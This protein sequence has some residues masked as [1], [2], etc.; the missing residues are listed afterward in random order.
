MLQPFRCGRENLNAL[1][2][3]TEQAVQH[4]AYVWIIVNDKY[5]LIIRG[6]DRGGTAQ[7]FLHV[8]F[9]GQPWSTSRRGA[10]ISSS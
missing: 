1:S 10:A 7:T 4:V 2:N 9:P 3:R 8:Q 5:D 6:R